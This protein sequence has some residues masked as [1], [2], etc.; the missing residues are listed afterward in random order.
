MEGA[1][2]P[3][4]GLRVGELLLAGGELGGEGGVHGGPVV[5]PVVGVGLAAGRLGEGGVAGV[6]DHFLE[7]CAAAAHAD[8]PL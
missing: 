6:G 8:S 5:E 2:H 4:G 7:V 1:R 3:A